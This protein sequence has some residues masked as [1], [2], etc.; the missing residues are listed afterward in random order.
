MAY[1]AAGA[2]LMNGDFTIRA[3]QRQCGSTI[4]KA[5]NG[6]TKR[7]HS[8]KN[9]L[10]CLPQEA[11]LCFAGPP[12]DMCAD[13]DFCINPYQLNP[14]VALDN[15]GLAFRCCVCQHRSKKT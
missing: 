13:P 6:R 9:M 15:I 1:T 3:V 7:L 14:N 12:T 5:Q 10:I 11:A 4:I 8:R 2:A